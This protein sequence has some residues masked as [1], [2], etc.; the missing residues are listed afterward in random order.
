MAQKQE[1]QVDGISASNLLLTQTQLKDGA[2]EFFKSK[3][4]HQQKG[5]R[6]GR[7][8]EKEREKQQKKRE[9]RR[10]KNKP[11]EVSHVDGPVTLVS[12]HLGH[13]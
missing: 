5:E 11:S 9:K 4:E 10:N 12:L 7:E 1:L 2:E 3:D 8:E 6:E 13:L